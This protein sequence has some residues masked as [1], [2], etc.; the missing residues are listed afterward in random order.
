M[1]TRAPFAPTVSFGEAAGVGRILNPSATC[2][3]CKSLWPMRSTTAAVVSAHR[4]ARG[5]EGSA[6]CSCHAHP[7]VPLSYCGI[8]AAAFRRLFLGRRGR[9]PIRARLTPA[10]AA[11]YTTIGDSYQK[12]AIYGSLCERR[13]DPRTSHQPMRQLYQKGQLCFRLRRTNVL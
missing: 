7:G 3:S 9:A 4:Q 6:L 11:H 8:P 5:D 13:F 1:W 12:H 10:A 2:E